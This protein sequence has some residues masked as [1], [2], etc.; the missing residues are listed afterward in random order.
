MA[1]T[2][3][4]TPP[5]VRV[6]VLATGVALAGAAIAWRSWSR[7]RVLERRTGVSANGME[8]EVVGDGPRSLLFIG[9][10]PG[11]EIATGLFGRLVSAQ[12]TPLVRAGYT[13]WNVT[14]RRHMPP[15][16]TVADMADDYARFIEDELG[17]HVDLVEGESFGGLVAQYLAANHPPLVGG[18]VLALSGSAVTDRGAD[19]DIRWTTA[20]AE[21]RQD[22]AGAALL[23]YLIPGPDRATLRRRLGPLMGRMLAHSAV[24][25]GDLL[26]EAQAQAACDTRDVLGRIEAPVLLVC[27]DKDEA[28][29]RD[30]VA[31]T[32]ALIPRSTLVWYPGM[33]HVA[34]AFSGRIPKDILDWARQEGLLPAD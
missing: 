11:S 9:G 17:G 20:R 8:F 15:G 27:G 21:G 18:V 33:G 34:A 12:F 22:D 13:V 31:E 32:A 26:V 14:R 7:P 25:V 24:P 29:A 30:V 2:S 3:G 4:G 19:L 5:I 16:H 23:E 1:A 28:F 6:A 10:G